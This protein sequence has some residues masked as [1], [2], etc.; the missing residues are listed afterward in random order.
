MEQWRFPPNAVR[1][2]AMNQSQKNEEALDIILE[3]VQR[4]Q[5][6]G[7]AELR[8]YL[9][10][11]LLNHLHKITDLDKREYVIG[12]EGSNMVFEI[13]ERFL[14]NERDERHRVD[15]EK[16]S[17]AVGDGIAETFL[18]L[19]AESSNSNI[20]KMLART[21]K[22]TREGF[23]DRVHYF[24]CSIFLTGD[25]RTLDVGPVKFLSSEDFWST[26]KCQIKRDADLLARANWE[27]CKTHGNGEADEAASLAFHQ[28][29]AHSTVVGLKRYF[30]QYLWIG[31]IEV[32]ACDETVSREK[33]LFL[34]RG[35][36]NI[37]KLIYGGARSD[38][39]RTSEDQSLTTR[40]F[41]LTKDVTGPFSISFK[42]A[43]NGNVMGNEWRGLLA[44]KA[45]YFFEVAQKI[46]TL[47][48]GFSSPPPLCDRFMGALS[49]YGDGVSESVPSAKIVKFV[50][51]IES[52]VGTGEEKD[53][54]GKVVRG[55]TEIVTVRAAIFLSRAVEMR[56]DE[57]HSKIKKIYSS[58]SELVHGSVSPFDVSHQSIA[59]EAAKVAQMVLLAG[60][61]YFEF[62]GWEKPSLNAKGL[63]TE[64]KKFEKDFN[65]NV[66][67]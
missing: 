6:R 19:K 26:Y 65:D 27:Q 57:A 32:P 38:R 28:K 3:A 4:Y 10:T 7:P 52:L 34:V 39:L 30:D 40:S 46:L 61:D 64:F 63:T 50:S 16:F 29:H 11:D 62:L 54:G 21:L 35:A 2:L 33:A 66:T 18:N 14:N 13:A 45:K 17:R 53:S 24:P 60:L 31:V 42:L 20:S 55:V 49:W 1:I 67:L 56:Y 58:R 51:A 12:T 23:K 41:G 37:L 9:R 59:N 44:G 36:L 5:N 48:M 47:M 25:K 15:L 22:R 43:A 8:E